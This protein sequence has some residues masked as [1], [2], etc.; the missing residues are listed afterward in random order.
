MSSRD[1]ILNRIRGALAQDTLPFPSRTPS[2]L[3]GKSRSPVTT[4]VGDQNALAIRFG[5]ELEKLSGSY[6][7]GSSLTAARLMCI[8]RIRSWIEEDEKRQKGLM[9]ET[10]QKNHIL[11]WKPEA[12]G[13]DGLLEALEVLDLVLVSP[14]ELRSEESRQAVRFIRYGLTSVTAACAS[15][16]TMV[17]ASSTV[18][19]SRS[20]SLLPYHHV[21]LIPFS[22]LYP[23]F[24]TWLA[25]M[26]Q[27]GKL[28]QQMR[29]NANI[30]FI[31]GPSK[32]ADI[33]G[34]LTLGVHG[35]RHVH[36]ILFDDI[37]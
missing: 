17:M 36:A 29:Q 2:P 24:E 12:L 20:A 23:S 37:E 3:D 16:G 7:I 14:E 5:K 8:S 4:L 19:T 34:K 6:E 26:R 28:V 1:A 18:G 35:P 9:L 31:S 13:I 15:T 33:E 22:R 21:A 27:Q 30:S 25:E 10:G 32:S 11:C